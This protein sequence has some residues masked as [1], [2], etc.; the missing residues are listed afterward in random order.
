MKFENT[1]AGLKELNTFLEGAS[2]I[3]GY[4]PSQADVEVFTAIGET[5]LEGFPHI[6]RWYKHI[7]SYTEEER[8]AFPAVAEKKAEEPKKEEEKAGDDDDDFDLFETTEEDKA[9]LEAERIRKAD[10]MTKLAKE[11]GLARSQLVIDIKPWD[12]ETPMDKLEAAV[13]AIE[14]PGLA[15]G[16]SKLVP[17]GYGIRKLSIGAIIIDDLVCTDDIEEAITGITDYVQSM[18]VASFNKL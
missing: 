16:I 2:Y 4:L 7:A 15:W 1:P 10:E 5:K 13:R 3:E 18:D 17:V 8:K 9:A 12:D 14:L 6:Q 11:K